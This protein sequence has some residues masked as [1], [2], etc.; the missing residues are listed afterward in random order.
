MPDSADAAT[1]ASRDDVAS[2]N[3]EEDNPGRLFAVYSQN[4]LVAERLK[5][6]NYETEFVSLD[7]SLKAVPRFVESNDCQK[8]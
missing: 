6:L 1:A 3:N 2:S 4:E 8:I 5:L 7:D